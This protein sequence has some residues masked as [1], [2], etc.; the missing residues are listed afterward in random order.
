MVG[1]HLSDK[2]IILPYQ[3]LLSVFYPKKKKLYMPC[4]HAHHIFVRQNLT[5]KSHDGGKGGHFCQCDGKSINLQLTRGVPLVRQLSLYLLNDFKSLLSEFTK[6]IMA[7]A[8]GQIQPIAN[9]CLFRCNYR[10]ALLFHH[11]DFRQL[12]LASVIC[13]GYS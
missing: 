5:V 8:V 12:N 2:K 4:K 9:E 3:M 10:N 11:H 6:G 13:V 7:L 1:V